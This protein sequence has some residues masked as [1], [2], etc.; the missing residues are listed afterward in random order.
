MK[1]R[2]EE[3]K[4]RREKEKRRREKEKRRREKKVLLFLAVHLKFRMC[5]SCHTS[6]WK[7]SELCNLNFVDHF[8]ALNSKVMQISPPGTTAI[9]HWDSAPL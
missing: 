4:R 8:S 7:F 1:K 6:E 3:V 2:K 5:T 9:M